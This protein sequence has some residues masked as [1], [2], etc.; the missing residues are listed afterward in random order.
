MAIDQG[1]QEGNT[2]DREP[3]ADQAQLP[4]HCGKAVLSKGVLPRLTIAR[5][6]RSTAE[7]G[8][9]RPGASCPRTVGNRY[10]INGMPLAIPNLIPASSF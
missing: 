1:R 6:Q 2:A 8:N 4:G 7:R 9:L 10:S 3:G 5:L